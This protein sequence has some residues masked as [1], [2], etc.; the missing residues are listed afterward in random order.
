MVLARARKLLDDRGPVDDVSDLER[1]CVLG[2]EGDDVGCCLRLVLGRAFGRLR[3]HRLEANIQPDN[4]AS[5]AL[6]R[7]IGFRREG[8]SPRY[9]KVGGR[10]RDH[11]RWALR[12]AQW[13]PRRRRRSVCVR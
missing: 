13:R 4:A 6:V 3:L 12:S 8:F 2:H 9:L 7:R 10:W 5:L 1:S 11:E